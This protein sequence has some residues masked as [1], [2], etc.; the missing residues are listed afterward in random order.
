MTDLQIGFDDICAVARIVSV[1]PDVV[2][3]VLAGDMGG[4]SQ[5]QAHRVKATAEAIIA[6]LPASRRVRTAGPG[7]V[8][9]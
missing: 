9:P 5:E 3:R 8:R 2:R 1:S 7:E 4:I 6:R